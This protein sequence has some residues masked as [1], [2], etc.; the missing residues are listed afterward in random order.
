MRLESIKQYCQEACELTAD[1]LDE[2]FS[3]PEVVSYLNAHLPPGCE[4]MTKSKINYLRVQ[5]ILKPEGDGDIRTSWRYTHDDIRRALVVELLKT[6]AKL[7]VQEIK[8]WLR[9]FEDAQSRGVLD[10]LEQSE[11]TREKPNMPDPISLAYALLRNRVLGTLITTLS[12]GEAQAI[13]PGCL[14]ALRILNRSE[15]SLSLNRLLS[16]NEASQLLLESG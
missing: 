16:W 1:L 6:R 15:E 7:S 10:K 5:E 4:Q 8:G 3:T 9:S 11:I 13:P 12:Y 14:I 2:Q